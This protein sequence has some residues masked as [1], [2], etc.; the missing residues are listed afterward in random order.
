MPAAVLGLKE[1][2]FSDDPVLQ[3]RNERKMMRTDAEI[4]ASYGGGEFEKNLGDVDRSLNLSEE[5][6]QSKRKPSYLTGTRQVR[7]LFAARRFEDALVE[8]NEL[9]L[10]FPKSSLLWTMKGTLHLRM[11]QQELSLSSYEKAFEFEPS[12]QLLAQIEDLRRRLNEQERLRQPTQPVDVK[13]PE[14]KAAGEQK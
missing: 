9:L 3:A 13:A 4:A 12:N 2:D 5:Q 1:S 14:D 11:R 7:E 8:V 6:Q 10:H